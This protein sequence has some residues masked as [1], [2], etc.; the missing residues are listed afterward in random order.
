MHFQKIHKISKSEEII[1]Y[2]KQ[3]I[4]SRKIKPGQKLPVEDSL[5]ESM[6]V[7]R[8]TVREA[9][10]VLIHMGLV[11]R[12]SNGTYI[13]E[14]KTVDNDFFKLDEYR[15]FVEI[16]ETRRVIEPALAEFAAK[17][18]DKELINKLGEELDS[19]KMK[20]DD[21]DAFLLHDSLF[22][23]LVSEASGNSILRS[24]LLGSSELMK[25]NQQIVLKKRYRHIMPKSLKFH[26]NIFKAISQGD[27]RAAY[28]QM[29]KHIVDIESE[30]AK[31]VTGD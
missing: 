19:M 9:L 12:K 31:I 5:A 24:F 25:K 8:G 4:I 3:Q 11:E 16:M 6:G 7:G 30:F 13:T 1:E 29:Q 10:G 17:R 21:V 14:R 22:H 2:L 26:E 27:N 28:L 18:G 15:D 23:D 20:M